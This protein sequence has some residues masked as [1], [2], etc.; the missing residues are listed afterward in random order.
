MD[1]ASTHVALYDARV[2]DRL[3]TG[4]R[5]RLPISANLPGHEIVA[6]CPLPGHE[7]AARCLDTNLLLLLTAARTRICSAC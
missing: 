4:P 7:P 2:D 5:L 1:L 3:W 6:R